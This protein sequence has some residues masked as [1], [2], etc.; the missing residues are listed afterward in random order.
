MFVLLSRTQAGPGRKVKQEQEEISRN[1]VP[2]LFLSSVHVIVFDLIYD[3]YPCRYLLLLSL[4]FLPPI[5]SHLSVFLHHLIMRA[6]RGSGEEGRGGR[7]ISALTHRKCFP[8]HSIPYHVIL[9]QQP[10]LLLN[11]TAKQYILM[12]VQG[13]T[14]RLFPGCVKLNENV[15][16][17]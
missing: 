16:F 17:C 7:A 8:N 10:C 15:A 14:E 1:H 11:N 13:C 12:A 4:S 3:G 6:S 9:G 5:P 2:I